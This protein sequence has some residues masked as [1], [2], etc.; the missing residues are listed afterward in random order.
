MRRRIFEFVLLT[1][2]LAACIGACTLIVQKSHARRD[3]LLADMAAKEKLIGEIVQSTTGAAVVQEKIAALQATLN[4]FSHRL[5]EPG[6]IDALLER[7]TRAA[8]ANSLTV[9]SVKRIS[10]TPTADF[11][12][13]PIV[14]KLTGDFR[15]FYAFLLTLEKQ[16]KLVRITQLTLKK[17]ETRDGGATATIGFSVYA[18]PI[19]QA[20]TPATQPAADAWAGLEFNPGNDQ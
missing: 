11:V 4:T 14:L 18:R 16:P 2:M 13:Q 3:V 12:E 6:E 17:S 10:P 15:H 8:A 7:L 19:V 5:A 20:A 1:A 9:E